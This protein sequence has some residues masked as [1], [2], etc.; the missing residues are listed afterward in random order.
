MREKEEGK[1]SDVVEPNQVN[2]NKKLFKT[3]V[4]IGTCRRDKR[5]S[6]EMV[7]FQASSKFTL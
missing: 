1:I 6:R 7:W 5:G 4:K 3:E 2:L